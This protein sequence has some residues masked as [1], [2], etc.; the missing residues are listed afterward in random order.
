VSAEGSESK[1]AEPS[2]GDSSAAGLR[3]RPSAS[4]AE[5]GGCAT[6]RCDSG[7]LHPLLAQQLRSLTLPSPLPPEWAAFLASVSG[8]YVDSDEARWQLERSIEIMCKE[9]TAHHEELREDIRKREAVEEAYRASEARL[10]EEIADRERMEIELRLKQKLESVGQLA[11]GIAHEINTP[12]QYVGDSVHFLKTAVEDYRGL[13]EKHRSSLT[14]CGERLTDPSIASAMR[15]AEEMAELEYLDGQVPKAFERISDG[16]S[17]VTAIVRAVKEFTHNE[18]CTS[19]LADINR[20]LENTLTVAH[21]EY[22][23]VADVVTDFGA[24]PDVYC[25]IGELNQV[26]L[27]LIV[28]AAHA[29]ADRT[30]KEPIDRGTITI[31]TRVDGSK[32]LISIADTGCGIPA[33]IRDRIFDPFFTTK[34]VGRGT[35]QGLAIARSIVVAKHGGTLT[36]DTT[37]G[38]G[39]TFY[40]RVPITQARAA[41]SA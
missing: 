31:V 22:K 17:R 10:L 18:Q 19:A 40:I 39:T 13:L 28:N 8:A 11:A 9:L 4:D 12:I 33:E 27:N 34:E 1:F 29:I 15:E 36:Y 30:P 14:A 38:V 21:N 24:L 26:F 7:S 20:A 37:P 2:P 5:G 16:V 3:G 23:Y 6:P 35:G 32:A 25:Q 41:E